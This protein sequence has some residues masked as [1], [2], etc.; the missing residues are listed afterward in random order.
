MY[1]TD[2]IKAEVIKQLKKELSSKEIVIKDIDR[3]D[4]YGHEAGMPFEE[5][6]KS[7]LINTV[8]DSF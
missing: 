3:T 1:K 5:W 6:V 4:V 2:E 7:F 8:L